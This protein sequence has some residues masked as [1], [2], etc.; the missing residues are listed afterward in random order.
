[1]TGNIRVGTRGSALAVTQTT[2][3]AEA[4]SAGGR[5]DY[6]LVR[7]RTEGDVLKGSLAQIGG[8][9]VFVAALREALLDDRCDIAVHSLKDLPT[10]IAEG[11]QIAA[12]PERVD[13]RDALCARDGLDLAGLPAGAKVG[14]G[15]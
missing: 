2:T 4:L 15:S 12:Y 8:T 1:M 10:G 5:L 6:E 9:G 11:L 7:I 14:T 13:V 3:V